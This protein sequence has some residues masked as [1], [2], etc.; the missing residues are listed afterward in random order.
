MRKHSRPRLY[1]NLRARPRPHLHHRCQGRSTCGRRRMCRSEGK[2]RHVSSAPCMGWRIRPRP[3]QRPESSLTCGSACRP[4]APTS[5]FRRSRSSSSPCTPSAA[6]VACR[7]KKAS[8]GAPAAGSLGFLAA[9]G[10]L[11]ARG[12]GCRM[13]WPSGPWCGDVTMIWGVAPGPGDAGGSVFSRRKRQDPLPE[14]RE[15]I[16]RYRAR[17]Q[18]VRK[19]SA[20]VQC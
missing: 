13:S 19:I 10:A 2:D 1:L 17:S 4:P 14:A 5:R 11:A 16:V 15:A 9:G 20:H 3:K 18:A 6:S 8:S 12:S 7:F